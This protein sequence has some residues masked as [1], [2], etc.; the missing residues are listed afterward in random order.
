MVP[1]DSLTSIL[2]KYHA[3]SSGY[4]GHAQRLQYI[5]IYIY[6]LGSSARFARA[7]AYGIILWDYIFWDCIMELYYGIILR[8]TITEL[9]CCIVLRDDITEIN[10][11]FIFR[12]HVVGL[13]Y[14]IIF[15]D[16]ILESY[17]GII[18]LKYITGLHCGIM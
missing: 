12:D 14:R 15:Q 7:K 5:N 3:I 2:L 13:N 1:A 10:H 17:Y 8:D 9:Y 4:G 16:Y 18:L 11:G 6:I